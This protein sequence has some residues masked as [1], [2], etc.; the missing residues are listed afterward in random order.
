M[1][2]RILVTGAA[3]GKMGATGRRVAEM[4]LRSGF[5]VRAFVRSQDDRSKYFRSLGAEIV[6]N[7]K[8][9][10]NQRRFASFFVS[11]SG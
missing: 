10:T 5:A 9:T 6:A 11:F 3:G 4:L 1:N 2:P 7:Q 8:L